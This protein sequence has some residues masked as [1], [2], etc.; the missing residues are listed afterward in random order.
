MGSKNRLG[1]AIPTVSNHFECTAL[2]CKRHDRSP[3]HSRHPPSIG[4]ERIGCNIEKQENQS[5]PG[6]EALILR[7]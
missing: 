4:Y 7:F 5:S 1:D 2:F 6:T 3:S